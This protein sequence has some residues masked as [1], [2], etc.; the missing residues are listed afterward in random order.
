MLFVKLLSKLPLVV[1]Y[2][3]ADLLYFFSCYVFR[4]RRKTVIGNL[5]KSFPEKQ[6]PE[7]EEIAKGFYKNLADILV[8]TIK[9]SSISEEEIRKRVKPVNMEAVDKYFDQN[10]SFIAMASHMCNWEWVGLACSA[11]LRAENVVI[12]QQ[13]ANLTVDAWLKRTRAVFGAVLI[14]KKQVLRQLVLRKDIVSAIGVI[15]DQSPAAGENR[16]W[17]DFL[18]QETAFFAGGEKIAR[19][20]NL[21]VVYVNM[22]R[23]KRGYYEMYFEKMVE[24]PFDVPENGILNMF[25]KK[26][27]ADIRRQ[28]SN[29]LWSHNRWKLRKPA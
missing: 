7:I 15:A 29:W 4:Y 11:Y 10:V 22:R 5:R 24:H 3:M 25:A 12:Y 16:Y 18:N 19:K 28:P 26:L 14:E 17:T 8:E 9:G 27:E 6:L 13:Q 20:F 1:L 2:R 23:I 21:P